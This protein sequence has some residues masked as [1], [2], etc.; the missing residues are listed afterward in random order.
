MTPSNFDSPTP[1]SASGDGRGAPTAPETPMSGAEPGPAAPARSSMHSWYDG[2]SNTEM[3]KGAVE[4][5]E[6]GGD[7]QSQGGQPAEAG[8][9]AHRVYADF[10]REGISLDGKT[11]GELN[12]I[13]DKAVQYSGSGEFKFDHGAFRDQ[14]LDR[15]IQEVRAHAKQIH[16]HQRKVWTDLN[17]GWQNELRKDSELGGDKLQMSLSRA[18]A[19]IEDNLSRADAKALLVHTDHNGMGNFP[20]FIKLLNNI[21]RK[22]NVY[23][24]FTVQSNPTPPRGAGKR[25]WYGPSR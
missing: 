13:I 2:A 21:G 7:G 22:L 20:I 18:K 3:V 1:D 5:S 17:A 12:A 4:P 15:H 9:I 25:D 14:L 24:D 11:V 23:E 8:Q 10:A 6:A 16:D 19:L